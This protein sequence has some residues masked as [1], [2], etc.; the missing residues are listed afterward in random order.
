MHKLLNHQLRKIT[1]AD[2][3]VDT[4][5]LI[6]VV[7]RSYA[8]FDRERRLNDRAAKLMEEELQQAN[9]RIRKLGDQRLAET[10]ESVPSR[11]RVAGCRWPG[12][13]HEFRHGHALRRS[14]SRRF[15]GGDK[16]IDIRNWEHWLS[17]RRPITWKDLLSGGTL[18]VEIGG[19][20]YLGAAQRSSDGSYALALPEITALAEEREATLAPLRANAAESANKL[21]SR[22]SRHHEP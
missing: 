1:Q 4:Q 19:C 21:K 14:R 5:A 9:S 20:W 22:I 10:L 2:G 12:A 7:E 13:K 17:R 8:E 6:A 11:Y 3:S 15:A 18:E 16:F